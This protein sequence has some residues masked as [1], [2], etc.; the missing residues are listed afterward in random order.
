MQNTHKKHKL[1]TKEGKQKSGDTTE[2]ELDG[3]YI[4]TQNEG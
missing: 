4:G 3:K 2:V 1:S